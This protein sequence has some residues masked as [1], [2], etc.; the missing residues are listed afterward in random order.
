MRNA[1]T[2]LSKV[3]QQIKPQAEDQP[4]FWYEE[5]AY[6]AM[7][8]RER[9]HIDAL[10]EKANAGTSFAKAFEAF[11]DSE[12]DDLERFVLASV[13]LAAIDPEVALAQA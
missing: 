7:S 3:E 11:T 10:I 4:W 13:H 5:P 8:K 12:R 6:L 9:K 2:R 1:L